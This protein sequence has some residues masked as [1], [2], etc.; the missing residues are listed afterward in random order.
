[1]EPYS[2]HYNS[3]TTYVPAQPHSSAPLSYCALI[4]TREN[5]GRFSFFIFFDCVSLKLPKL[6][7]IGTYV[8]TQ[9]AKQ[10]SQ[11]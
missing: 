5:S 10:I 11:N 8:F 4:P 2:P 7:S 1:M 9:N 3:P 6:G